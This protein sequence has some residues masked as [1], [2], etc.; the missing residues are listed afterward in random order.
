[1]GDLNPTKRGSFMSDKQIGRAAALKRRVGFSSQDFP[2]KIEGYV[3]GTDDYHWMV[4][5]P[6]DGPVTYLVHKSCPLVAIS[7]AVVD[8]D[9]PEWVSAI[10]GAFWALCRKTYLGQHDPSVQSPSVPRE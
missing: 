4:V 8:E 2:R 5:V 6:D 3:V 7:S 1:M 10:G 9:I